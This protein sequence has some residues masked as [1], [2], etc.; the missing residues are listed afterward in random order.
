MATAIDLTPF[1]FPH[2]FNCRGTIKS[3]RRG[4]ER[5]LFLFG[6]RHTIKPY[7]R[8]NVLNAVDLCKLGIV[9][10][11]GVEGLPGEELPGREARAFYADQQTRHGDNTE[12]IID[13]ILGWLQCPDFLF[14][15]TLTLLMPELTIES[16]EDR[17]LYDRAA[18]QNQWYSNQRRDRIT[19]VLR[20]SGLFHP[21]AEDRESRIAE[22][23]NLQWEQEL[24]EA[25]VN[26]Q[27]DQTFLDKMLRLWERSGTDKA[28][29]L[30][31]GTAHQYRLAR[32]LPPDLSY[33]HIEQP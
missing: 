22:K 1:G 19:N 23:A 17:N 32:Q 2:V 3:Q 21:N 4:G 8:E 29:I 30:N 7:I 31:A 16:V 9:S 5:L 11:V 25:E 33:Y 26:L 10:S 14:W 27:R 28:A 18:G 6:D 13:A 12:A 15:K 24:A 20:R